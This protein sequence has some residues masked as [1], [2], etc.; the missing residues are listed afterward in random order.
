MRESDIEKKVSDYAKRS[1]WLVYKW[2]SPNQRGVPDRIFFKQGVTVC[3]EF[4]AEGKKPSELQHYHMN[5][6][7]AAKIQCKVIDSVTSGK[8]FIDAI[9]E[10]FT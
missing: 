10:Q 2:V 6:L 9:N 5:K 4:K 1:G 3:I 7:T 8:D